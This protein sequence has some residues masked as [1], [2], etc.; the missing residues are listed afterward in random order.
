MGDVVAVDGD[1]GDTLHTAGGA[2]NE[3][4]NVDIVEE[5]VV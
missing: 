5:N 4:L 1:V 3:R 2:R